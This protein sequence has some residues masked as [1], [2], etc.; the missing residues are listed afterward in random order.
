M[1]SGKVEIL[2]PSFSLQKKL[3]APA[4]HMPLQRLQSADN[5]LQS[6][7]VGFDAL[8]SAFLQTLKSPQSTSEEIY[9]MAH[10]F[11]CIA[12]SFQRKSQGKIADALCR[13]VDAARDAGHN[14]D[15]SVVNILKNALL[16]CES[17]SMTDPYAS[18][19]IAEAACEA[20]L[21]KI[22]DFKKN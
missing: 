16:A 8:R 10:E 14:P 13:Y 21:K 9:Q 1:A 17:V 19:K 12:G 2:A 7:A 6:L 22:E 15:A 11:R 20:T 4:K 3:G 5:A 18:E